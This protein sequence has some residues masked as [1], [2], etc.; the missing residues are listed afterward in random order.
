MRQNGPVTT[1]ADSA[2]REE[3]L[4][5][6]QVAAHLGIPRSTAWLRVVTRVLP[7]T[8]VGRA[9]IVR[10][11]DVE[12]YRRRMACGAPEARAS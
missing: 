4:T 9:Y 3:F 10:R 8:R 5:V 6:P 7:A 12:E 11:A 2:Q 1:K